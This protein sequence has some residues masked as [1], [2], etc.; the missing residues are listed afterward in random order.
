LDIK[1]GSILNEL[2]SL[3]EDIKEIYR[4]IAELQ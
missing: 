1:S 2:K 3:R 4:M